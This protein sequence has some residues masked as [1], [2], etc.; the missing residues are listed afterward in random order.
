MERARR[1]ISLLY[2]KLWM[3]PCCP[4]GAPLMTS[5]SVIE[6]AVSRCWQGATGAIVNVTTIN[7]S[8][9]VSGG[10]GATRGLRCLWRDSLVTRI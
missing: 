8:Q 3:L 2:P 9:H 10:T 6:L 7:R 5:P 4:Y 1:R